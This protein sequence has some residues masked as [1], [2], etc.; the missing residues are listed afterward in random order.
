MRREKLGK[1]G[2]KYCV[3]QAI[4]RENFDYAAAS[5]HAIY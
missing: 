3:I 4:F 2:S 1:K 5:S